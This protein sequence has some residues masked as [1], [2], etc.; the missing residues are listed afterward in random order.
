VPVNARFN[1]SADK[2]PACHNIAMK[3][4]WQNRLRERLDADP[5]SYSDISLAAGLGR[6]YIQQMLKNGK[7][8][9][10]EKLSRILEELGTDASI[11][12]LSGHEFD[13]ISLDFLNIFSELPEDVRKN[14]LDM[15]RSMYQKQAETE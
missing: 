4:G 15:F 8:P 7:E 13:P 9:G 1:V 6:N 5:R 3:T 10:V 11:Y 14:T 12:V 2:S